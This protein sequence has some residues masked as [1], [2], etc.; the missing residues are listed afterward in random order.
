MHTYKMGAF[1]VL[2]DLVP[3]PEKLVVNTNFSLENRKSLKLLLSGIEGIEPS[4]FMGPDRGKYSCGLDIGIAFDRQPIGEAIARAL[5]TL[6]GHENELADGEGNLPEIEIDIAPDPYA[7]AMAREMKH[8]WQAEQGDSFNFNQNKPA[9]M[10]VEH[11]SGDYDGYLQPDH[12]S[13]AVVDTPAGT[14]EKSILDLL[15][16]Y[17]ENESPNP[18]GQDDVPTETE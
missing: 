12:N 10:Y 17:K 3:N 13:T 7:A 9:R 11:H 14:P 1:K 4:S 16:N 6:Q 8:S 15:D 2:I 5:L 18:M